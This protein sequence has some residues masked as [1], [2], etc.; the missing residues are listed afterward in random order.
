MEYRSPENGYPFSADGMLDLANQCL[1]AARASDSALLEMAGLALRRV[2]H[3]RLQSESPRVFTRLLGLL[4]QSE[5]QLADGS[6]SYRELS[7]AASKFQDFAD[8]L[9]RTEL[10]S[11]ST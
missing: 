9:R 4:E 8:R 1:D 5:N 3:G 2:A 11:A 7:E 6:I 10:C